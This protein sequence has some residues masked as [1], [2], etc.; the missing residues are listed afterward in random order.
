MKF[1]FLFFSLISG[2]FLWAQSPTDPS[3]GTAPAAPNPQAAPT[4]TPALP[5]TI[6]V[7]TET[8]P[9]QAPQVGISFENQ[10]TAVPPE[11][12]KDK[13]YYDPTV[14]RDPFKIPMINVGPLNRAEP[15]VNEDS[16]EGASIPEGV[17]VLAIIYDSKKPRALVQKLSNKKSYLVFNKSRLGVGGGVVSEIREDEIV[18]VRSQETD[19][20]TT[21]EHIVLRLNDKKHKNEPK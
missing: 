10:A 18:V 3:S 20:Q 13:F 19:G 9:Q 1:I 4:S 2:F 6:P 5:A 7:T 8:P 21:V 15:V 12:G 14:G 17:R 16:L 11:M